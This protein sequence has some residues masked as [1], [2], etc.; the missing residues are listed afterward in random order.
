M[1]GLTLQSQ[2]GLS[3][4]VKQYPVKPFGFL[5]NNVGKHKRSE[6]LKKRQMCGVSHQSEV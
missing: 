2:K 5:S 1:G 3:V 4:C 6:W